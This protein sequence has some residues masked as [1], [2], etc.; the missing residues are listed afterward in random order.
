MS[1]T[2]NMV[3]AVWFAACGIQGC[4]SS[5]EAQTPEQVSREEAWEGEL[6][7]R[8][9]DAPSLDASHE[10]YV[11]VTGRERHPV[12]FKGDAP[13]G[14]RSG[15]HVKLRGQRTARQL[16]AQSV[17]VDTR[18]R[19]ASST[20]G[21]C[22]VT[23][24]QR[25]LVIMAAFPGMAT[26]SNTPQGMEEA[27]F[28]TTRR[29][30]AGYWSE[31]SEGRT[32]TTG[33]VV[34]W[35]T[36]DRAYACEES[37]AMRTAALQAADADVDFTQYDRIFIVHPRPQ[38]GCYYGGLAT[39]SCGQVATPDGTVTASTA[40]LVAQSMNT[41]DSAVQLITHEAGHNLSLNH[42]QTRDFD[43]EPLSLLNLAGTLDEYGDVF[44]TM[45]RWNL[46]HY[47][48]PH[49]ARIGWLAPSSVVQV[50]GVG[51]TFTL[52]P[53]VASGG[54]KALK[55]RRGQGNDAWLWLEYRQQ[56]GSYESTLPSQVFGGALIHYEDADTRDGT[57]LLDFTP[58]TASWSD[59]A[60]L[61]GTTWE[62][63]Y[64][65]LSVTVVSATSTALTVTLQ[66]RQAACIRAAPE[67]EVTPFEPTVWP[68]SRP[69]VELLIINRDSVGCTPSVFQLA[70]IVPPGWSSD[71]LPAQRTIAASGSTSLTLQLYT[72]YAATPGMYTTGVDVTRNGHTV[73]G[74]AA[75]EVV[76]RCISATPTL[77]LSPTTVTASPGT[78]VTW[79]VYVQNHDSASCNW[80]WYD[81]W[82]NDTTGWD[83]TW[84]DW[85]VNLPPGG[86]FTFTMTKT[87]PANAQGTHT[88]GLE[89][90]Q[91]E[92][93]IVAST[94]AT[95]HVAE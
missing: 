39:L 3:A 40:W 52:A 16:V 42:S 5:E 8:V 62:D 50:D 61:P 1:R 21:T 47:A 85:G 87:I 83:T 91:D 11:L 77:T 18:T 24:V 66:Y 78:D 33:D 59:P 51:G 31:V 2:W 72:P 58:G 22:G 30:L 17:E 32:T 43:A 4:V 82:N 60:L 15:L 76:E 41:H 28:S 71:P 20:L 19:S 48:V 63:P 93:G 45:G 35:Y 84:S 34:G 65:N 86:D 44:S 68:G 53:V 57:H 92:V 7:V 27:F 88:V 89:L 49:K 80:V 25:S 29:S 74:T 13:K 26:P 67:V 56:V 94:T 75:Q 14:L 64:S 95:V 12:V 23:G 81:F 9:V 46:G 79:T 55:V 90:F 37:D 38:A 73:R 6:E 10:E 54:V 70:A 36:L 69:E